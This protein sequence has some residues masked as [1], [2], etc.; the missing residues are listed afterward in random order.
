MEQTQHVT[1]PLRSAQTVMHWLQTWRRTS[2]GIR[3]SSMTSP[4]PSTQT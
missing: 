4:P 1:S 3:G 2:I